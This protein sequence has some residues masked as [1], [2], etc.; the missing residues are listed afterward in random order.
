MRIRVLLPPLPLCQPTLVS[1][2]YW[3]AAATEPVWRPG[4]RRAGGVAAGL[5]GTGAPVPGL[6]LWR[7]CA[8][9]A[10]VTAP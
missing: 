3:Q 6:G 7:I 9:H 10:G 8:S 1:Q 5:A 4:C 2:S